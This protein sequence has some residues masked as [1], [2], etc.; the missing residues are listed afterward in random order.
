MEAAVEFSTNSWLRKLFLEVL[1]PC[2]E[3]SL[4]V[5]FPEGATIR[6]GAEDG[7]GV[8]AEITIHSENFFKRIALFGDVGFGEAF[9]EGEWSSPEVSRVICWFLTNLEN[10][11]TLSGSKR[12]WS[13]VNLMGS[14][15]RLYHLARANHLEGSQ[16]N[17]RAH[18]DFSNEFFALWLDPTMTYSSAWFET[19][20]TSLEDGQ[21]AKYERLLS[22]LHLR[23]GMT[24]LEIGSGWGG[25]GILAARKYGCKVTSLTLSKNQL[26]E[27][28]RRAAQAG[29]A[30]R[31]RFELQDYRKIR[32]QFDRIVSIEMIEAVGHEFHEDYFR[33][34]H[35]LLK[36]DGLVAIQ[37]ILCPDTRYAQ[38]KSRVDW[39]QRYIFPGS[40][41]PSFG[42]IQ[43]AIRNTGDLDLFSYE[44]MGLHYAETLRRWCSTMMAKQEDVKKLGHDD[45]EIRRWQYYFQYCA[46]AFQMRNIT[47]AQ[48]VF[49]RPNNPTLIP[50]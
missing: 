28:Q 43:E 13:P 15:H 33:Q 9:V 30:D 23:P 5:K 35:D 19:P 4:T 11:P 7:S 12:R 1:K 22:K 38:L 27:A 2:R 34:C 46:G 16:K 31:V 41:L 3:G 14:F 6:F 29:V 42:R 39:I 50:Q 17:I 36:H 32:G 26:Q 40:L 21:I 49:S 8:Q 44:E 37:A 25:L 20:E 47:V 18:Y 10:T 24:L 45:R 48:L